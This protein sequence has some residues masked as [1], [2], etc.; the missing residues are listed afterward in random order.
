MAPIL[1]EGNALPVFPCLANKK[2][3]T[4]HGF[5]DATAD[6]PAIEG[7][8][9]SHWGP[10]VGLPT[11]ER[12]GLDVLDIDLDGLSWFGR[13][14]GRLT[15]TRMHETRSGGRHLFFRH[16]PG[17]RCS[18][19]KIDVGIDVRADGGYVIWWPAAGGRVLCDVPP[20]EW[21]R[22]LSSNLDNRPSTDCFV[23]SHGE[24]PIPSSSSTLTVHPRSREASYAYVALR[25]AMN[26]L[27]NAK[28]GERNTKL[29]I[30][31]YSLGRLAA[32][33]WITV[34]RVLQGLELVCEFNLLT[35]DD[36]PEQVRATIASGLRAGM[37]R[38]YPDDIF[39]KGQA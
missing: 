5:K 3:A 25:H 12:S 16:R 13:N 28:P 24:L 10:L 27:L 32:R 20:A 2:P 31:A 36:G 7:L 19:S 39:R 15:P 23:A 38:P 37:D 6:P 14:S 34:E 30:R 22:W 33:G 29:N 35:R 11:G 21:P 17:L 1:L 8:W 18:T 26:E 9:R 4:P